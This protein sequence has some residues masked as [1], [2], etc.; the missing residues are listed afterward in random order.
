MSIGRKHDAT[1]RSTGKFASYK[2]RG[3]NQPPKGE[4]FVWF[5]KEMMGSPALQVASGGALHVIAQ[6][7][8]EHM[9]NGGGRNGELAVTYANFEGAGIRRRKILEYLAEAAALGFI[10]RTQEG[11]LS[12]GEFKGAPARYRLTWLP[13]CHG[14]PATND[15]RAHRTREDAK[16]AVRR[17]LNAIHQRRTEDLPKRKAAVE[18]RKAR[19]ASSDPTHRSAA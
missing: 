8:V 13:T 1:G 2:L 16:E 9:A 12:W 6:I 17:A 4:A 18:A 10:A 14:K 5:T 7:A 19:K 11:R 3:A 15:W